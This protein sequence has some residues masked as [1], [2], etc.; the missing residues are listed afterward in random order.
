MI[1]GCGWLTGM[2]VD[3]MEDVLFVGTNK[4]GKVDSIR[5][6]CTFGGGLCCFCSFGAVSANGVAS[7]YFRSRFLEMRT[8]GFCSFV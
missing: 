5:D 3:D 1:P 4:K 7:A 6:L 2:E 8:E